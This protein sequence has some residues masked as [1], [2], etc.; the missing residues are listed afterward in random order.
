[1]SPKQ[2][3]HILFTHINRRTVAKTVNFFKPDDRGEQ[4]RNQTQITC[5]EAFRQVFELSPP[6][7]DALIQE[8]NCSRE[9]AMAFCK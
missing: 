3:F 7:K 4:W 9:D 5:Y 2:K 1:M 8:T 6:E